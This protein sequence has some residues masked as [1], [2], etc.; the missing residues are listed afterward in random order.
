MLSVTKPWISPVMD[1]DKE[2]DKKKKKLDVKEVFNNDDE[3]DSNAN[4]KKRKL[5]PL[6]KFLCC[7]KPFH[8]P[9][10][11]SIIEERVMIIEYI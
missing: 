5:V 11:Q 3:D 9:M 7:D 4:T 8:H 2:K 6:G 10:L 1:K